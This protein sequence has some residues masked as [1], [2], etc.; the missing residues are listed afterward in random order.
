MHALDNTCD[1]KAMCPWEPV[2][3]KPCVFCEFIDLLSVL[4]S[5]II[6]NVILF[7]FHGGKIQ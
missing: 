4:Y 2:R 7:I 6:G 5:H 1:G 3:F